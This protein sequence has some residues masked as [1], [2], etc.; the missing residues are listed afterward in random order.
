MPKGAND[1]SA[2]LVYTVYAQPVTV[3]IIVF[4]HSSFVSPVVSFAVLVIIPV[5]LLLGNCCLRGRKG[6]TR[7][8]YEKVPVRRVASS[9]TAGRITAM[10]E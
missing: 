4:L 9:S 6:W 7:S 5:S 2:T 10:E 8:D 1:M 3:P